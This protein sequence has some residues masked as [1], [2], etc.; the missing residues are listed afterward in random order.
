MKPKLKEAYDYF[1]ELVV[2]GGN[3]NTEED[4]VKLRTIWQE[5]NLF[6]DLENELPN[7]FKIGDIIYVYTYHFKDYNLTI[8]EFEVTGY[9]KHGSII[10]ENVENNHKRVSILPPCEI[11]NPNIQDNTFYSSKI[12]KAKDQKSLVR[13]FLH[14]KLKEMYED[15]DDMQSEL[16]ECL[17][18]IKCIE[19][20][21]LSLE[22]EE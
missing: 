19:N 2:N 1:S 7:K 4:I 20:K 22:V 13:A 16:D 12:L 21:M 9:N 17:N 10:L 5:F 8:E 6:K 18:K 14:I 15:R 11:D 3:V